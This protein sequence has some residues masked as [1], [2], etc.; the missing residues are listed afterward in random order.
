MVLPPGKAV[1]SIVVEKDV[2]ALL[3]KMAIEEDRP[4]TFV[5]KRLLYQ[6]M[7]DLGLIDKPKKHYR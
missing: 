3:V 2:K 4:L 1:L 6:A 7:S 5:C